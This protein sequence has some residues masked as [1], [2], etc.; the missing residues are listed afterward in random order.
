MKTIN[1]EGKEYKTISD[2]PVLHSGWEIDSVGYVVQH[3][4]KKKIAISDHGRFH[5][6]DDAEIIKIII[7]YQDAIKHTV[8]ALLETK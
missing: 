5:F 8:E 4:D 6:A 3:D 1:I 2:F 7:R